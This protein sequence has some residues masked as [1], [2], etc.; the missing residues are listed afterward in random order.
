MTPCSTLEQRC[1]PRWKL[2]HWRCQVWFTSTFFERGRPCTSPR[3]RQCRSG[4]SEHDYDERADWWWREHQAGRRGV[5]LY[6]GG[7]SDA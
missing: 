4:L 2:R 6:R 3:R 1:D 7:C 5:Y